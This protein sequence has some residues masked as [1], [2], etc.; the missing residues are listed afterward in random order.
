MASMQPVATYFFVGVGKSG[1][2]WLYEFVAR[3]G[4]GSV[5]KLKEPHLV[6]AAP[7]EQARLVRTL[8]DS[9]ESMCDFSNTYYV[10]HENP[11]RIAAYNPDARVVITC[12]RPTKRTESHFQFL[13]RSGMTTEPTLDAYLAAGDEHDLVERSDYQPIVDRY[14][15]TFPAAQTLVL[16]LE[17]LRLAPQTYADTLCAFMRHPPVAL[18]EQDTTPVLA[19]SGPRNVRLS[20]AAQRSSAMLRERGAYRLLGALKRSELLRR[21][22]YA[23]GGSA[24]AAAVP[25]THT[26]LA[27][28]DAAYPRFVAEHAPWCPPVD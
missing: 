5:P 27:V 26:R 1:T 12:R 17:G 3:H 20:R 23:T 14:R 22:M 9:T 11:T 4:L 7:A 6:D 28:L 18:T 2:T 21:A 10:D 15:T 19:R 24:T 8:F 25:Q 13:V 16:P